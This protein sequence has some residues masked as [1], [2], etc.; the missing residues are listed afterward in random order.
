MEPQLEEELI[1]GGSVTRQKLAL[2]HI[3]VLVNGIAEA[4]AAYRS[5]GARISEP[6]V[7][8]SQNVRVCFVSMGSSVALELVEPAQTG[9]SRDLLKRGITYYH[10]GYMVSD[11]DAVLQNLV[12]SGY[13]H[14]HTFSSEAFEGRRCAFLMS[15]V[16]HLMELIEQR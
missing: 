15:P 4:S 2:H 1:A 8:A 6:V 12:D 3:G 5:L 7:I 14:L 16:L 13:V 11:F 10:L 9:V